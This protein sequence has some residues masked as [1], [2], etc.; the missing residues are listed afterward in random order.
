MKAELKKLLFGILCMVWIALKISEIIY[1]SDT[2]SANEKTF[3][4][5]GFVAFTFLG[6]DNL[7]EWWKLRKQRKAK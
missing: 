5:L 7:W 4:V 6:A 3:T 1:K 2:M